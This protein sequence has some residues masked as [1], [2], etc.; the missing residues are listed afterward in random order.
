[1]KKY[2]IIIGSIV[3]ISG[4]LILYIISPTKGRSNTVKGKVE[5]MED[6]EGI[7]SISVD[8]SEWEAA[9]NELS[10]MYIL[11]ITDS[12]NV[13]SEKDFL[14]TR[15]HFT[16]CQAIYNYLKENG[17]DETSVSVVP[18]SG[19]KEGNNSRFTV[20]LDSY[21]NI[22]LEVTY[23]GITG[24]YHFQLFLKSE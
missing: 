20:T 13:L 16:K 5:I 1:M 21:P 2:L 14:P 3:I 24:D 12:E 10:D 23:Y 8:L 6:D 11:S 9:D 18:G 17:Y 19:T 22:E 15:A 7:K 4:I